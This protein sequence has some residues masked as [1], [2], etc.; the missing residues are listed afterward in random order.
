MANGS[1]VQLLSALNAGAVSRFGVKAR[2]ELT[3]W[4]ASQG[5][6]DEREP[7][8]EDARLRRVLAHLPRHH[9]ARDGEFRELGDIPD[10]VGWLEAGVQVFEESES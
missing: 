5:F 8:D 4:L 2:A 3:N 6:L 1:A 10:V 7:L 9:Q